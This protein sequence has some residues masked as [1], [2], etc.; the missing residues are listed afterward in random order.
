MSTKIKKC[1]L[2]DLE[3]LQNI[4]IETY[5]ETYS[6]LNT[7]ENMHDYLEK[8]FSTSQLKNEL[9]NEL[10]TFFLLLEN[11]VIAG[12]LKINV[13]DAQT[14]HVSKE[15]ALEIERIYVK[16]NFQDKGLGRI[17]LNKGIEFA[18]EQNKENVWLGVW[19]KNKTAIDFHRNMGFEVEGEYSV[20]VGDEEHVNYIMVKKLG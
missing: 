2:D 15:N 5:N 6:H 14:Q 9:D 16:S 12:Y 13:D 20:F 4:A 19:N 3:Q 10:S 18:R 17:L 7:P 11:N 8:A 1:T